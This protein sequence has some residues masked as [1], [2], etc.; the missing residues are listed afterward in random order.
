MDK[1]S[2]EYQK[3]LDDFLWCYIKEGGGLH[4]DR[5]RWD[6]HLT[7]N[8]NRRQ[9]RYLDRADGRGRY[10]DD[11]AIELHEMFPEYGIQDGGDLWGWLGTSRVNGGDVLCME[12]G[13]GWAA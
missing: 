12:L 2:R 4:R 5:E 1:V 13:M 3:E 8:Q 7:A 11:L 10:L 6:S 9:F